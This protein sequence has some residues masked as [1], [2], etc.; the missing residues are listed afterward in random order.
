MNFTTNFTSLCSEAS[1]SLFAFFSFGWCW[2]HAHSNSRHVINN[3]LFRFMPWIAVFFSARRQRPKPRRSRTA[4]CRNQTRRYEHN[5]MCSREI[6]TALHLIFM[7]CISSLRAHPSQQPRLFWLSSS[8]AI[9]GSMNHDR[10]SAFCV[11]DKTEPKTEQARL[12]HWAK[13][14]R[15]CYF[16]Q[17]PTLEHHSHLL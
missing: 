15:F 9:I 10:A 12:L 2:G 17:V 6:S 8:P 1:L 16:K 13:R 11:A 5:F 14:D 3:C 4:S 7:L